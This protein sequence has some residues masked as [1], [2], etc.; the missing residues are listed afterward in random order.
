LDGII[1]RETYVSS[2]GV[3]DRRSVGKVSDEVVVEESLIR[4][5]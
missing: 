3:V 2:S 1:F 4:G 5:T